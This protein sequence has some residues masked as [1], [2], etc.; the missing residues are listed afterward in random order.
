MMTGT[1]M[2][3]SSAELF[4]REPESLFFRLCECECVSECVCVR[5]WV[6]FKVV[7]G[8]QLFHIIILGAP[9]SSSIQS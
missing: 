3:Q 9:V 7:C 6:H 2:R 5:G 1:G 4:G 8:V